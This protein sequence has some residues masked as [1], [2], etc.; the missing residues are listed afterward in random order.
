MR[1]VGSCYIHKAGKPV[2][3][4]EKGHGAY[5]DGQESYLFVGD[6]LCL[7]MCTVPT[8]PI[9]SILVRPMDPREGPE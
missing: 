1:L 3:G 5:G 9:Y 7:R 6:Q 8:G 2:R 4:Y